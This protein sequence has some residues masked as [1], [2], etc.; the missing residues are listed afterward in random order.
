MGTEQINSYRWSVPTGRLTPFIPIALSGDRALAIE[1]R[2]IWPHLS[3]IRSALS[4]SC[5][6]A[7]RGGGRRFGGSV[8]TGR[9][10]SGRRASSSSVTCY[11]SPIA[12]R[13]T[14]STRAAP[15]SS[16]LMQ[17]RVGSRE[18][19]RCQA[20][21]SR[22]TTRRAHG[23]GM[24]SVES[25]RRASRSGRRDSRHGPARRLCAHAYSVR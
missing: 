4:C 5:L 13:V 23:D 1:P 15:G 3:P 22:A 21:S 20:G 17:R 8:L 24:V 16:S 25:Y 11:R 9:A 14:S 19:R 7:L 6:P 2:P 18:S 10:I 12:A